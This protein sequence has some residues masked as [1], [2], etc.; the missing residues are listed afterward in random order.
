MFIIRV[1]H[2]SLG[3]IFLFSSWMPDVTFRYTTTAI[4]QIIICV[5]SHSTLF[6]G[7]RREIT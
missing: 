5:L 6:Y 3:Y 4:F 7:M 2:L 1:T